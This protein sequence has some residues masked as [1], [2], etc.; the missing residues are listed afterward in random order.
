M[1]IHFTVYKYTFSNF[2]TVHQ[3]CNNHNMCSTPVTDDVQ[4]QE[5][6]TG[7]VH[8]CGFNSRKQSLFLTEE[9]EVKM[10]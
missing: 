8:E 4:H 1:F 2:M 5:L 7:S 9:I 3:V 6:M 10:R